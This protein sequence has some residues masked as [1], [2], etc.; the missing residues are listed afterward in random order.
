MSHGT[1]S[2]AKKRDQIGAPPR[3]RSAYS[4][5]REV[6]IYSQKSTKSFGDML[7]VTLAQH[8]SPLMTL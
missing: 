4:P 3:G 2:E 8:W 5:K 1:V 6:F 7:K